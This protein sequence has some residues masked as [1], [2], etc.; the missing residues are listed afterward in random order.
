MRCAECSR[1][2]DRKTNEECSHCEWP[3]CEEHRLMFYKTCA[4]Y[5][6]LWYF[7]EIILNKV[8][9]TSS[10]SRAPCP[11]TCPSHLLSGIRR[12]A[13]TLYVPENSSDSL[14]A[15]SFSLLD[16]TRSL[17]RTKLTTPVI[18]SE[19]GHYHRFHR[20]ID[21][22]SGICLGME[23]RVSSMDNAHCLAH[24]LNQVV[25][26]LTAIVPVD[27]FRGTP[28]RH[29]QIFKLSFDRGS[30]GS[31]DWHHLHPLWKQ[32]LEDQDIFIATLA[33]W[34]K[35][36]H[37]HRHYRPGLLDNALPHQTSWW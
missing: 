28:T 34:K 2:T 11:R 32:V 33:A 18:I 19:K 12:E 27:N 13:T 37:N 3:I 29:G 36:H 30:V 16:M 31:P 17:L 6:K 21:S 8:C 24:L 23:Q 15:M 35:S 20:V 9:R 25:R 22:I 5:E 1:K 26:E 10:D 14:S 7:F 4:K